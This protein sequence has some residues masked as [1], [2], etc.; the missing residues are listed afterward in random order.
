MEATG[1]NRREIRGG[2]GRIRGARHLRGHVSENAQLRLVAQLRSVM[3]AAPLFHPQTRWGRAMSVAMTSA[4]RFGWYSDRSGYR[5]VERHPG[6][7]AW[8]GIPADALRI[9]NQVTGLA[10]QPDCCLVNYYG[11][12]ARMGLHQDRDEA[13]FDWPVLSVSLGDEAL[14]RIGGQDRADRTESFWLRSGD[15]VVLQAESRLA[16]HGIDRIRFGSSPLLGEG[17]RLNLTLR[18]VT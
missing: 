2:E 6:G 10:R 17:G 16:Y 12:G 3:A 18:V 1:S 13:S 14:F 8:P 7:A 5:Y 15:V 11:E 9:W 4:G